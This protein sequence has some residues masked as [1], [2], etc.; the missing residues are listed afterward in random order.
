MIYFD[1]FHSRW[2]ILWNN[3]MSVSFSN[4]QSEE[5]KYVKLSEENDTFCVTFIN[6][7]QG[8]LNWYLIRKYMYYI[9][10]KML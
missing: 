10:I 6:L 9:S 2:Y 4:L 5:N 1:D 3:N 7:L 8:L